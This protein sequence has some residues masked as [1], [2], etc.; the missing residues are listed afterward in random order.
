MKDFY[1]TGDSGYPLEPWLM[2]PVLNAQ[3]GSP[4]D[5]YTNAHCR[6]RVCVERLNGVLKGVFRCLNQDRT[7][8]YSPRKCGS[9]INACAVL[10]NMRRH[11]NLDLEEQ[12]NIDPNIING[13]VN[14]NNEEL[15]VLQEGRLQ[16]NRIIDIFR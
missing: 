7:L 5:R 16:R 9:I 8:R 13:D 2:T 4:E 1:F 14:I 12:I 3:P 6:A 11:L 15:N 10:H